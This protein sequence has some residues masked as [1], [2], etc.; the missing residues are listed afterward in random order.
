MQRLEIKD[1]LENIANDLKSLSN[2]TMFMGVGC[3]EY[4]IETQEMWFLSDCLEKISTAIKEVQR[5]L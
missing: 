4:Q 2:I 3:K 1:T 5:D